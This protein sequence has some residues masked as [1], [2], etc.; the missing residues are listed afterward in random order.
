MMKDD[1]GYSVFRHVLGVPPAGVSP[2]NS[3]YVPTTDEAAIAAKFLRGEAGYV[4]KIHPTPNIFPV[5]GTLG[6]YYKVGHQREY[7]AMGGIPWGQVEGYAYVKATS[8]GKVPPGA[9]F[10]FKENRDYDQ[11]YNRFSVSDGQ[12]QLAGFQEVPGHPAQYEDPWEQYSKQRAGSSL[13]EYGLEFMAKQGKDLKWNGHP[14]LVPSPKIAEAGAA[15]AAEALKAAKEAAGQAKA[16]KTAEEAVRAADA[17]KNAAQTAVDAGKKVAVVVGYHRYLDGVVLDQTMNSILLARKTATKARMAAV[18]TIIQRLGKEIK[19]ARKKA[20]S[21]E[22]GAELQRQVSAAEEALK[23]LNEQVEAAN[24][25]LGDVTTV[26]GEVA[27]A[28]A[29]KKAPAEVAEGVVKGLI[30]R[31]HVIWLASRETSQGALTREREA[32]RAEANA[33]RGSVD[34]FKKAAVEAEKN[35]KQAQ[36]A[37]DRYETKEAGRVQQEKA[38]EDARSRAVEHINQNSS[39]PDTPTW[40]VGVLA[41]VGG[42]LSTIGGGAMAALAS[43]GA[44]AAGTA[45][46]AAAAAEGVGLLSAEASIEASISEV[47]SVVAEFDPDMAIQI[48]LDSA[49]TAPTTPPGLA[50]P[51]AL[52]GKRALIAPRQLLEARTGQQEAARKWAAQALGPA[53]RRAVVA[54]CELALREARQ[55]MGV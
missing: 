50:E 35:I 30:E 10:E 16:A 43:G 20:E 5:D 23:R 27:D 15:R 29:N 7:V 40:L 19:A 44:G 22:D 24:K 49:P 31:L 39:S 6:K 14:P 25:E 53:L 33:V 12:P 45:A 52:S 55:E 21:T 48:L 9:S 42:L 2:D 51:V 3:V 46:A 17:A 54:A 34:E 18:E 38:A 11:S 32:L 8:D 26:E 28:L 47:T 36:A 37:L 4:Y 1:L 13:M 41:G